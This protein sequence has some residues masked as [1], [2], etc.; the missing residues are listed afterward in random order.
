MA[1]ELKPIRRLV[2]GDNDLG[3]SIVKWD[4]PSPSFVGAPGTNMAARTWNDLWVW[5]S[6]PAPL[7]LDRDDGKLHYDFPGPLMGGHL[8][9]VQSRGRTADY[10]PNTDEKIVP[11]HEPK[12]RPAGRVW[13]R[14]G[15]NAYTSDMHKTQTIDYAFILEGE[16]TLVLDDGEVKWSPGDIVIQVG[17]WHQWTSRTQNAIVTYD[18]IAAHFSDG[19]LDVAK[20]NDQVMVVPEGTNNTGGAKPVRR[21]VTI[22]REPGK[23]ELLADGPCPDVRLDKARPGYTSSRMWVTD[24]TPAKIVFETLGLPH[25]I[26]PPVNGSVLRVE[27]FP[28]DKTWKSNVGAGEVKAYFETMGSPKASTYSSNAPHPYMQKTGALD[29]CC[30]LDG[31]IVLVLDTQEVVLKKGEFAVI[32]GSNHA[33]SN[34]TDKPAVVAIASHAAY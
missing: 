2:T 23:S 20:G 16:R 30:V 13:D 7:G 24:S 25:T 21:I 33:W 18:M 34:L 31:E 10:D 19:P 12:M 6:V 27:T 3:K 9:V 28:P 29:F 4:G 26:E 14:G 5:E 1:V 17:A 11:T 8:R 22:D 15:R 32:R